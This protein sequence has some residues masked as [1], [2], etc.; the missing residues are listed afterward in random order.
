MFDC[1]DEIIAAFD[2][3]EPKG[4]GKKSSAAPASLFKV[5]KSCEKLKQDKDVE[6]HNLVAN[7][8]YAA[9]RARPDTCTAISF[10]TTRVQEPEKEDWTKMVQLMRYLRDTRMMPLIL[11]ANGKWW[12]DASFPVHPNI[13][14]H[15]GGRL[16]S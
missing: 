7:I 13:C 16:S 8:L 1:V 12:V 15:S 14:G 6:F 9:K 11:S 3:A 2:K 10:L 5:D 4:G